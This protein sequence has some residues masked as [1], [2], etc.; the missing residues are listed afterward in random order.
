[1]NEEAPLG[2]SRPTAWVWTSCKARDDNMVTITMPAFLHLRS[3]AKLTHYKR[4]TPELFLTGTDVP[5]SSTTTGRRFLPDLT[6][7]DVSFYFLR[8]YK[9]N[10]SLRIVSQ[11]LLRTT[12]CCPALA[13]SSSPPVPSFHALGGQ[14]F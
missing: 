7:A 5:F 14:R 6:R 9:R 12:W 10:A 2:A 4:R 8:W 1:M 13:A 11:P 3:P